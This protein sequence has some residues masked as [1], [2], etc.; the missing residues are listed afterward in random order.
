MFLFRF[1]KTGKYALHTGDFRASYELVMSDMLR[2]IKIE[3][4]H[5]DTTYCD[6][7]YKFLPQSK[8]IQIGVDLA[9]KEI[10]KEPKTLICCGSY[11]IGKERIFIAIAEALNIKIFVTR[12]KMRVIECL[13][14]EKLK[15]MVTL[16][17]NETNLHVLPMGK[18]NIKVQLVKP[19]LFI[20]FKYL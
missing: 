16:N 8:V 17:S 12:D 18:L 1:K 11:T 3:T 14:N 9:L 20:H 6:S 15:N 4:V 10:K 5:L 19:K 13:E 2:S 7:Y